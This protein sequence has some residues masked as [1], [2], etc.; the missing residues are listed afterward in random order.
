[1]AYASIH[2][3]VS[4][5][6]S[7]ALADYE[8][9]K[10]WTEDDYSR[11][12]QNENNNY[13]YTRRGLNFTVKRNSEGKAIVS[14]VN[15]DDNTKVRFDSRLEKLGFKAYKDDAMNQPNNCVSMIITGDHEHLTKLAYGDQDISFEKGAD[16]SHVRR[17]Q[18]IEQW[19]CD[20]YDWA[21]EKW[22]ED[23][24]VG[25]QVH[26]DEKTPHIHLT[27]IPVAYRKQRG[28]VK[29]GTERKSALK[30]SYKG[31]FGETL[32]ERGKYCERIHTDYHKSVG[33]KYGLKRGRHKSELTEEEARERKHK[34]KALL[35]AER[36]AK[37]AI[38]ALNVEV[39][40]KREEKAQLSEE[41][42]KLNTER[43]RLGEETTKLK[44]EKAQLNEE[45]SKLREEKAEL[46]EDNRLLS[47]E[48]EETSLV[49]ESEAMRAEQ[50]HKTNNELE[51][52]QNGFDKR[53][54][55]FL[56]KHAAEAKAVIEDT[57]AKRTLFGSKKDQEARS[58]LRT[59]LLSILNK[60]IDNPTDLL[61]GLKGLPE[62]IRQEYR[63]MD[64]HAESNRQAES[65][66]KVEMP[67]VAK[68]NADLRRLHSMEAELLDDM[69]LQQLPEETKERLLGGES[70]TLRKKWYDPDRLAFTDEEEAVLKVSEWRLKFNGKSLREFLSQIWVKMAKAAQE[71]TETTKRIF[72]QGQDR[73]REKGLKL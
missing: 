44:E 36:E 33:A 65:R 57:S 9:R 18:G 56:Q 72:T 20:S 58:E 61:S 70:V 73:P 38:A 26:M 21:C 37:E 46:Q 48:F 24:I 47:E 6:C 19:A 60:V 45:T 41:T 66:S 67:A 17:S 55:E 42:N 22:G 10:N 32:A 3:E 2:L 43:T 27:F 69:N 49:K 29:P 63:R 59:N 31:L 52:A 54:G 53:I 14:E 11:K 5:G 64:E 51:I 34:S 13:D 25:F 7:A 15:S 8:C 50:L 62:D 16:N 40:E 71:L 28:R 12:N 23:N 1:M 68:T 30:V 4:S 35:T 39:Y